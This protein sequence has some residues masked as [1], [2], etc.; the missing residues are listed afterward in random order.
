LQTLDLGLL[1]VPSHCLV[2]SLSSLSGGPLLRHW[3]RPPLQHIIRLLEIFVAL[4]LVTAHLVF[5]F[6]MASRWRRVAPQLL[7]P[8]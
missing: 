4:L 7:Q 2:V 8:R 5:D 6:G 3:R 1:L